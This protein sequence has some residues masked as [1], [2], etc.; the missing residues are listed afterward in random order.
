MERYI[1]LVS[2]AADFVPSLRERFDVILLPPYGKLQTPVASHPDM[3]IFA[4]GNTLI[5]P[6]DYVSEN[7][8][9]FRKAERMGKL[10]VVGGTCGLRSEYPFDIAYNV[11]V[12]GDAALSLRAHTA[13]EILSELMA[14]GI[15]HIDVRQGYA[16][17]SSLVV[18][19]G[20]VTADPS[21]ADAADAVGIDVLRISPGGIRLD[22]YG[23][24]FIGGAS[25]VLG[26]E[27]YFFGDPLLHPDGEVI[28]G[29][30]ERHGAS[31]VKLGGGGLC[32]FGGIRFIR[33]SDD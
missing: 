24:G 30:I 14:R 33:I 3:L 26:N 11:L 8:A 15:R 13:P 6:R 23:C 22:G 20:M 21:V 27:V 32:D 9:I 28:L 17:C 7:S 4:V 1:A 29:F 10:R 16:A 12:C 2:A 25:A 18:N 5:A 31:A 19:G